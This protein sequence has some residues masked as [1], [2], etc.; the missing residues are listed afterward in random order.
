[1]SLFPL[2]DL[3]PHICASLFYADIVAIAQVNI[4]TNRLLRARSRVNHRTINA[5]D[6]TFEFTEQVIAGV[7]MSTSAILNITHVGMV[8]TCA[9]KHRGPNF[10]G[11]IKFGAHFVGLDKPG[12]LIIHVENNIARYCATITNYAM[13]VYSLFAYSRTPV[14]YIEYVAAMLC[15]NAFPLSRMV[16]PGFIIY[17][18]LTKSLRALIGPQYISGKEN[19][20]KIL[21]GFNDAL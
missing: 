9:F 15:G 21:R 2:T 12:E 6:H 5:P 11:L 7:V 3:I 1:M 14:H 20:Q 4:E 18:E 19:D 8:S 16:A 17:R 13:S 10:S